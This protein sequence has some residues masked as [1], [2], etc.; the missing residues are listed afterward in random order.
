MG[1]MQGKF[2][3]NE[4]RYVDLQNLSEES[5]DE[6]IQNMTFSC[7][8]YHFDRDMTSTTSMML[9]Q[10]A[11]AEKNS[12]AAAKQAEASHELAIATHKVAKAAL[13]YCLL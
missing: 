7:R 10:T 1:K 5:L 12:R 8:D 11:I 4:E 13:F 6:Y 2:L 9:L 3:K